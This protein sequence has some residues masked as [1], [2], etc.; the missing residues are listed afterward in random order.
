MERTDYLKIGGVLAAAIILVVAVIVLF[1]SS[2]D[3]SPPQRTIEEYEDQLRVGTT[4]FRLE[5]DTY[6][7]DFLL[8]GVYAGNAF[9]GTYTVNDL[10]KMRISPDLTPGDEVLDVYIIGYI[11]EQRGTPRFRA[12]I[13]VDDDFRAEVSSLTVAWGK[14]AADNVRPFEPEEVADGIFRDTVTASLPAASRSGL[15]KKID[16]QVAVGN[17]SR[18]DVENE[19]TNGF[20][21]VI[22]K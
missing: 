5:T 13:Y 2:D 8:A 11:E 7:E 1:S 3:R 20:T 21:A 10:E 22:A 16:V 15:Q 4:A 19:R 6:F 12:D 9:T 17:F 14:T 18:Q